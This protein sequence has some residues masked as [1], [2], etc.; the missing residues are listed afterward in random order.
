MDNVERQNHED[1]AVSHVVDRLAEKFPAQPRSVIEN[2]VTEERHLLDGKPIREYVPVLIEHG[3][4]AR[5][6]ESAEPA[7]L[8]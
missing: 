8:G 5:L 7:P 3:A 1:Q 6:R 2:V 4:K